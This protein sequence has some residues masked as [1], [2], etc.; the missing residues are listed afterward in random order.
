MIRSFKRSVKSQ[1]S[2]LLHTRT[3]QRLDS[4]VGIESL[5]Q[6]FMVFSFLAAAHAQAGRVG[7]NVADITKVIK[8]VELSVSEELG[9]HNLI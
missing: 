9:S 3:P 2:K 8:V 1:A 7:G 4:W 6:F 5:S